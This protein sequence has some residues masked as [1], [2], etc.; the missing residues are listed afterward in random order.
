MKAEVRKRQKGR[1]ETNE[2]K[3]FMACVSLPSSGACAYYCGLWVWAF[4]MPSAVISIGKCS[5]GMHA[6]VIAGPVG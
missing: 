4:P 5:G 1:K 6:D 2:K 3:L